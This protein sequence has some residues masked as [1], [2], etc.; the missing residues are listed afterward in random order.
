[1]THA[2]ERVT[3]CE[4]CGN[5]MA[6]I[7]AIAAATRGLPAPVRV[8]ARDFRISPDQASSLARGAGWRRILRP[9]GRQGFI[10]IR[11]L[12]AMFST[13]GV[14]GLLLAALPLLPLAGGTASMD[15][16]GGGA[17]VREAPAAASQDPKTR[18][19]PSPT[20]QPLTDEFTG[21][22][23]AGS[24]SEPTDPEAGGTIQAPETTEPPVA[25]ERP[26]LPTLLVSVSLLFLGAGLG[27][28]VL[29]RAAR[30]LR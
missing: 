1:M 28:F 21:D 26:D 9:F 10:A 3:T 17:Q 14:A 7:R 13:L 29:Q 19:F 5:L 16:V 20:I 25:E 6:E 15:T 11:P 4:D 23:E 27:L 8:A 18:L 24:V 30:R 22:A 12:A 2:T